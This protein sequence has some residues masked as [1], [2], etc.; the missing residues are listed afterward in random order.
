M[1]QTVQHDVYEYFNMGGCIDVFNINIDFYID[2]CSAEKQRHIN[3]LIL[4]YH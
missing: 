2:M 1:T 3:Y 4:I